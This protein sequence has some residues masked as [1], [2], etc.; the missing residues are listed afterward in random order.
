MSEADAIDAVEHPVTMDDIVADCRALG[1][2]PG[3]TLLVHASLSSL[4][5]V[6]GGPQAVVEGLQRAV[7]PEGTLVVPA[8]TPQYLDPTEWNQ[9]PVPDDWADTITEARPP[10]RPEATPSR[11][12]GAI[13]ECLRAFPDTRRSA[14]PLYSVAA[15][16]A[17]AEAVTTDHSLDFGL[18]EGTPYSALYDRDASV[19]LLGVGH[20]ANTSLH[21]AE[22]RAD[23][24]L[25]ARERTA[26]VVRDG[27]RVVVS[28]EDFETS[29]E[30]FRA[31]GDAFAASVGHA[32]GS[33]GAGTVTLVDQ[34]A[35]VDFAADWFED[36]R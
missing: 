4:G 30:D 6:A 28:Y 36:H 35:L 10:F 8:H 14:H 31:V 16:G 33:V 12:V 21:L 27:D 1:V 19:L 3:D 22:H 18:G 9:P 32:E 24:A 26:P 17:D 34:P 13:P 2:S 25:G 5:W 15:W 23:I 7:T 11:G 29:T 20:E